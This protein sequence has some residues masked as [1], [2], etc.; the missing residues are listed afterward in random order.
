M[1]QIRNPLHRLTLNLLRIMTGAL[2]IPH[3]AQKLFGVLGGFGGQPGGTVPLLSLMGLAGLLEFFGGLLVLLGLFTRPVAFIL[4]GE[5][6]AA[7]FMAHIP[8]GFW[9]LLN[10]GELAAL[11]CFVFLFLS[12][13]GGGDLS[14][15]TVM[16]KGRRL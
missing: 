3:G 1:S 12:A 11:Y 5:M 15:D 14:L 16:S 4:S 10:R 2:F 8:Q 7:Y 13:S 9:P 6:A